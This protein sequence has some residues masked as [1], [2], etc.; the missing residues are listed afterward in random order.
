M[1]TTGLLFTNY[2]AYGF[3]AGSYW[4]IMMADVGKA[5]TLCGAPAHL[6]EINSGAELARIV[7]DGI[8]NPPGFIGTFNFATPFALTIGT[9]T[10]WL[11]EPMSCRAVTIF[12]DHPIHMASEI[13]DFE[14]KAGQTRF[15]AALPPPPLYGVMEN[16][17]RAFLND[18][19]IDDGRILVV[20]QAG[21]EPDGRPVAP[22]SDRPVPLLFAGTVAPLETEDAFLSMV[23][24]GETARTALLKVLE[25]ALANRDPYVTAK[26]E[27]TRLG[28]RQ[29]PVMWAEVAKRADIRARALRRRAMLLRFKDMP[30]HFCGSIE[31]AFASQFPH[32]VFHGN[33]PFSDVLGLMDKTRVVLNDTINLQAGLLIRAFY[34]MARGCVLATESNAFACAEFADG[35][36]AVL[37][38]GE[39]GDG[40]KVAALLADPGRLQAVADAGR[41]KVAQRHRWSDR[42]REL[43]DVLTRG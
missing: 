22:L 19:G 21:P 15:R 25:A 20:S 33:L 35:A 9:E 16:A 13:R 8:K 14:A 36:D 32:A 12:L 29:D 26:T 34:A 6:A 1:R 27:Y 11:A 18:M 42:V 28:S 7:N 38:D 39:P 5:L 31:D 24:T 40:E 10:V 3:S 23:G 30:V 43:A 37:L 2:S 4:T 17:H 41:A